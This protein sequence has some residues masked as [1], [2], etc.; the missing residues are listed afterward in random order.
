MSHLWQYT[1]TVARFIVELSTTNGTNES[2]QYM[3]MQVTSASP[4]VEVKRLFWTL[5]GTAA[6]RRRLR[7]ISKV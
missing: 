3:Y 1:Q 7:L 6:A 5:P 2:E 4:N